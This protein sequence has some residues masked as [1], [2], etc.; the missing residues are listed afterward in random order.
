M[1]TI[2]QIFFVIVIFS[3]SVVSC[4]KSSGPA[5]TP[6]PVIKPDTIPAGWAKIKVDTNG[7]YINDIFFINNSVGYAVTASVGIIKS[8]NGGST[9]NK[10]SDFTMSNISGT[11]D[12]KAF[13]VD[14]YS[15]ILTKTPD[16]GVSFTQQGLSSQGMSDIFFSDNNTGLLASKYQIYNTNNAGV[17]WNPVQTI[18]NVA[19]LYTSLFMF[20]NTH[21]WLVYSNRVV[22]ASTN[23]STWQ[24]D[25]VIAQAPDMS[26][27]T[28]FATSASTVYTC[29]YSGYLYK[30]TNGGSSFTF[31]QKLNPGAIG[32]FSDLYFIDA[33]T[34]Y[35]SVGSRIYKTTDAGSSWQ[36]ILALG[37]TSITEIHFTDATHGWACCA[38]G[39]I[40]K[41]N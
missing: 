5:A 12:G 1:K 30:S 3:A 28:I 31:L 36:M 7:R 14:G 21:A 19:N 34:G 27:I 37:N 23:L 4:S 11:N 6:A 16:G 32:S 41:L 33:N 26:L 39:T 9:W 10:V 20:D 24:T 8:T 35:L 18:P 22:H 29:S 15:N 13:F 2:N 38:D 17:N 25:T 40:L